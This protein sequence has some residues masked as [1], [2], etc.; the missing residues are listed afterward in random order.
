MK[1]FPART[2]ADLETIRLLFREYEQFL[3]VDLCFQ[4]FE[5]ELAGLPGKYAPPE[6]A[7]LLA[8]AAGN[9]AGCVALRKQADKVCEM[10]RLYVRPPYHGRGIG[11]QLALAVISRARDAGYTKMVL[12]TL[13]TLQPAMRL[14]TQLGFK[15]RSPYYYNPLPGAVFW[16]LDLS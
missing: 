9:A 16:Q 15:K 4:E 6:G 7:L 11:R 13:D 14:Y 5:K 1:I 8:L 10:K 12:D 2:D 3:R